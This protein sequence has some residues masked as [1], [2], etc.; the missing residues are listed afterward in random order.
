MHPTRSLPRIT[1][2]ARA[3]LLHFAPLAALALSSATLLACGG[4]TAGAEATANTASTANSAGPALPPCAV[5]DY[6]CRV[7]RLGSTAFG[8]LGTGVAAATIVAALGEPS[9]RGAVEEEGASGL[10]L[11]SWAWPRAGV[12]VTMEATTPGGALTAHSFTVRAPFTER[13]ARGVGI[14]SSEAAVQAAY[15]GLSDPDATRAG[16]IF[17]AGSVYG[18]VFFKFVDGR[19]DEIFVGADAE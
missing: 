18:G 17:V 10:F 9:T 13:S 2:R 19:V 15:E 6:D 3:S 4:A 14:G 11:T 7:A 16:E 12:V 5:E 8:P 1:L